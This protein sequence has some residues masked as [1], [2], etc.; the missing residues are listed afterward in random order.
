MLT[1]LAVRSKGV[2]GYPED[3][4][5]ACRA[6]LTVSEAVIAAAQSRVMV[7]VQPPVIL[8]FYTLWPLADTPGHFELDALFVEPDQLRQGIGRALIRDAVEEVR[9]SGGTTLVVQSDPGAESFYLAV[10]AR[11]IGTRE[12]A[13]VAGRM[14]PLLE[15]KV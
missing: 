1:E 15:L 3:F 4:M 10:G 5:R 6:E 8:G 12:S 9:A 13:S 14:L 11:R 7:A 2:W